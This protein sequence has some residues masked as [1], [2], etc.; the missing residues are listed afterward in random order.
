MMCNE[1]EMEGIIQNSKTPKLTSS[2][3]NH[4]PVN[5]IVING[6]TDVSDG[7]TDVSDQFFLD[8]STFFQRQV[9]IFLF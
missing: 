8:S 2:A 5:S 3:A 7:S 6:S 9:V 4:E 1:R